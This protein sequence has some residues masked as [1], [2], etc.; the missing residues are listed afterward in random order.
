VRALFNDHQD[1]LRKLTLKFYE[2][3]SVLKHMEL[4]YFV[5]GMEENYPFLI[6]GSPSFQE[7]RASHPL[8]HTA[9][10]QGAF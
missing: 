8:L 1:H 9:I 10:M 4:S 6:G 2:R 5:S 7:S 3:I